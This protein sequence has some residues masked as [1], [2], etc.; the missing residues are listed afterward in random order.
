MESMEVDDL[1][2][3]QKK[4]RI[5]SRVT[6]KTLSQSGNHETGTEDYSANDDDKDDDFVMHS[7]ESSKGK[8]GRS[9]KGSFLVF[10]FSC[11]IK[12]TVQVI[13]K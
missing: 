3:V 1:N 5:S 13:K 9:T 2:P 8:N 11:L 10:V 12:G 6:R 7:E 4:R